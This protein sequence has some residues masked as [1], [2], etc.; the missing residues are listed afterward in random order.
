MAVCPG[1]L[2]QWSQ[3]VQRR[4][5][6]AVLA[7]AGKTSPSNQSADSASHGRDGADVPHLAQ[8]QAPRG[9]RVFAHA[10]CPGE[11]PARLSPGVQ[12]PEH[13]ESGNSIPP[14]PRLRG[15]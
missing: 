2:E 9:V 1:V 15:L 13:D 12:D 5:A 4:G 3:S 14:P 7:A 11:G 8:A 10:W 6:H